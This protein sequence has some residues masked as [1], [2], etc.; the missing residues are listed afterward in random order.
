MDR[1]LIVLL[2]LACAIAL[3]LGL[4]PPMAQPQDY[5]RFVDTRAWLGV[6]NF[7]NVVSNFAFL[8]VAAAGLYVLRVA[9]LRMERLPYLLFFLGLAATTFGSAWYHLAPDNARL[10]WD[11]L[12]IAVSFAALL[13]AVI[14]ERI[15]LGAGVLSLAPLA[16]T[17]AGTVWYW[18]YSEGQGDGNV[19]P[20]FA[21]QLYGLLAILLLMH[22]SPPRFTRDT[23]L[24]RVLAL[25]GAA[26]AA[27]QFDQYL[28]TLGGIVSGHTLKHLLAALGTYQL[29]RM[30]R[31]R[32]RI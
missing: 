7:L 25:Y 15:S 6:P 24:Y 28:F 26:V 22:R 19:L 23:D 29:V 21:F 32:R 17:G 10:F 20:Y 12:P 16:A 8:A 3:V 4:L 5:H 13:S 14:S 1:G 27:E 30:L 9:P 2:L 18:L 31:L 11:R